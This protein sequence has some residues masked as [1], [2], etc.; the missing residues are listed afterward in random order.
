[1]LS[2]LL[3]DAKSNKS[4]IN[5]TTLIIYR[6]GNWTHYRLHIPVIRQLFWFIYR[7]FD[8]LIIRVAGSGELPAKCQIGCGLYLPHGVN[9]IV[10]HSDSILGSNITLFHQVT[11][12]GNGND[13]GM[14]QL[15][16]NVYIGV[17]AKLIGE[18]KIGDSVKIGANA[19]VV[20]DIPANC[21]VV[22]VPAKII[23]KTG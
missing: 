6:L 3:Q 9:G 14:P 15:G 16:N 18:I 5:K 20:S 22:G 12:G 7:L 21:T 19:V 8:F 11:I 13:Y 1:M 4:L 23:S 10:I 2:Y 17:G